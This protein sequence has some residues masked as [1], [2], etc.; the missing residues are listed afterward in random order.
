MPYLDEQSLLVYKSNKSYFKSKMLKDENITVIDVEFQ[1]LKKR[2]FR[3]NDSV[4][5][6][7]NNNLL[8]RSG[9]SKVDRFFNFSLMN[10]KLNP[11]FE[12]PQIPRVNTCFSQETS[13]NN[14]RNS[15]QHRRKIIKLQNIGEKKKSEYLS[16]SENENAFRFSSKNWNHDVG[17]IM[18]N[19]NAIL[20]PISPPSPQNPNSNQNLN[21]NN[22]T[23]FQP[24]R[25]ILVS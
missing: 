7:P 25:Q 21:S 13:K 9:D 8:R 16:N 17:K 10:Y 11:R 14:I 20:K 5:P 23:T 1:Q 2:L 24:Q 3:K 12:I 18:K 4:F 15:S 22:N 6:R 19:T